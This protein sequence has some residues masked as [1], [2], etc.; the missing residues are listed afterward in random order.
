[1]FLLLLESPLRRPVNDPNC[2]DVPLNPTHSLQGDQ[3]QVDHDP[4]VH[5]NSADCA[6]GFLKVC[7]FL[8]RLVCYVLMYV[9][10]TAVISSSKRFATFEGVTSVG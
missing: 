7:S 1:M 3:L 4:V 5:T 9:T 8:F 10:V 6:V 2:V